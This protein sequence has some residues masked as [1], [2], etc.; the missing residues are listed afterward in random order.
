MTQPT[1]HLIQTTNLQKYSAPNVPRL[2]Q[3]WKTSRNVH[4]ILLSD[5]NEYYKVHSFVDRCIYRWVTSR[6]V[7]NEVRRVLPS[8]SSKQIALPPSLKIQSGTYVWTRTRGAIHL[9]P[10]RT[11]RVPSVKS[12]MS[13]QVRD[14]GLHARSLSL[15]RLVQVCSGVE[16]WP[17]SQTTGFDVF[18]FFFFFFFWFISDDLVHQSKNSQHVW[19]CRRRKYVV[20]SL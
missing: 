12:R 13:V 1:A 15:S 3:N 20:C 9:I 19:W 14:A 8:L 4:C 5:Y 6:S 2:F 11:V 17:T 10:F 18:L 16:N 7:E